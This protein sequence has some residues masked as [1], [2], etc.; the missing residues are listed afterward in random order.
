MEQEYE[1][2]LEGYWLMEKY[3]GGADPEKLLAICQAA[4]EESPLSLTK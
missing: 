4:L 1:N 2:V 3:R